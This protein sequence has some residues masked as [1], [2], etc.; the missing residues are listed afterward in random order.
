MDQRIGVLSEEET[1][2]ILSMR[3]RQHGQS[4]H[5]ISRISFPNVAMPTKAAAEAMAL[6]YDKSISQLRPGQYECI[7]DLIEQRNVVAIIPTG[8]GKSLIWLWSAIIVKRSDILNV[9]PP[10]SCSCCGSIHSHNCIASRKVQELGNVSIIRRTHGYF[11]LE[12]CQLCLNL[13]YT[14]KTGEEW[15]FQNVDSRTGS[16]NSSSRLGWRTRVA[17]SLERRSIEMSRCRLKFAAKCQHLCVHR[18]VFDRRHA[19]HDSQTEN[20]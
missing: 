18:N 5:A 9:C 12:D 19:S 17:K 13:L 16:K 3:S 15:I 4:G 20:F 6:Q 14:W 2:M 10:A 7:A 1:A 8:G 11:A